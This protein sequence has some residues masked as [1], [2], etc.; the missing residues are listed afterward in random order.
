MLEAARWEHGGLA[1]LL[2]RFRQLVSGVERE[3]RVQL[4]FKLQNGRWGPGVEGNWLARCMVRDGTP[5]DLSARRGTAR[6]RI[7]PDS[8]SAW[9]KGLSWVMVRAAPCLPALRGRA[10]PVAISRGGGDDE[11]ARPGHPAQWSPA[12][13]SGTR[14]RSR[15]GGASRSVSRAQRGAGSPAGRRESR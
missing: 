3:G 14:R 7:S 9:A 12:Q 10:E 13:G 5:Q 11:G 8:L 15:I 4:K 6:R 2:L 1:A